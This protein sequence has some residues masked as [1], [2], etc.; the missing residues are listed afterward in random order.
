LYTLLFNLAN[1]AFNVL[2]EEQRINF[3]SLVEN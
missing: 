1:F 3:S 2:K